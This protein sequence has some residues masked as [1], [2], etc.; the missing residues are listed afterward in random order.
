MPVSIRLPVIA[1][2]F[3][4]G[5]IASWHKAVGDSVAKG[6]ILFDIET[7]KAVVEVEADDSG[8]LGAILVP[9]GSEA[10][11]VNAIVGYLLKQGET[12]ADLPNAGAVSLQ[13][14]PGNQAPAGSPA[15]SQPAL[16]AQARDR[17]FAS[18]LARR[19]AVQ[20]G[21]E[22]AGIRGSGPNGRILK[23]D[24]E[25]VVGQAAKQAGSAATQPSVRS[26]RAGR[27]VPNS[28]MRKAIA[29]RLTAAKRDIPHFYLTID[30]ELDALLDVRRQLNEHFA[31]SGTKISV[32]DCVIKAAALALADVP[33]AN[34]SWSDDAIHQHGTVDISVAV[35]TGGGLLT[36]IIRDA[37]LKP[38][39][40]IS[41]EMKALAARA[42]AGKLKPD[43]FNGGGF[44]VSNLGM[45]GIKA[46]SAIL[47][48]P[49]SCI[50]AV[51]AGEKRAV[52][53]GDAL[54][55]ATVMTCTLS[56]DH[57]SVDGAVGAQL[58]GAFKKYI[59]NPALLLLGA[60]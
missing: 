19:L 57:R 26:R 18:P 51:G 12:L 32:N 7:D 42:V 58:L 59:E 20:R 29:A 28:R 48:P 2:D 21:V 36:P 39:V 46:F 47:N 41:R 13:I 53:R 60:A 1:A 37:D 52:V 15:D 27:D 44:S 11:P 54:A 45:Y 17:T 25:A 49:Q 6:E 50:L 3:R 4:S 34:A 40:E 35:A 55:I 10:V 38:L 14:P 9:G 24:V 8:V 31:S 33:A 22:L 56:V 16:P 23:A 43:E 30:C 5:A